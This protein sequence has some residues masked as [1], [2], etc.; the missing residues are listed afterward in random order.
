MRVLILKG[1]YKGRQAEVI[2]EGTFNVFGRQITGIKVDAGL[3][4]PL[5]L[6]KDDYEET[7]PVEVDPRL[8]ELCIPWDKEEGEYNALH[9]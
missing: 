6:Q 8:V 4:G 7:V 5:V 1:C 3:A 9:M 2:D